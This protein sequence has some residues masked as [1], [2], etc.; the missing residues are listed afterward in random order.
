MRSRDDQ[1][2]TPRPSPQGTAF[3]SLLS[4]LSSLFLL[5]SLPVSVAA[6]TIVLDARDCDRMA[7]IAESAPRQSWAM[8]PHGRASFSTS[9]MRLVPGRCLLIRF[10]L[11][12]VP[13]GHR[14]AHSVLTV[15]V[16][17]QGGA[18]PRFYVWRVLAD[19]GPGVC[20]TYRATRPQE[21]EWTRPGAAGHSSD[22][23]T[24]PTDIVRLPKKPK[25]MRINVTEDLD[26]WYTGAAPNNGF[27]ISVEDPKVHVRLHSP[28]S[29]EGRTEWKLRITY[30]PQ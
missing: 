15:P 27:L 9:E 20:Y 29:N 28:L 1:Q 17:G 8:Q 21:M 30:E 16:I 14:I 26:L 13:P 7:A 12:K 11:D 6:R 18:E 5:L 23:A 24:R 10:A 4:L 22:R 25:P 2:Y 3:P 19:W